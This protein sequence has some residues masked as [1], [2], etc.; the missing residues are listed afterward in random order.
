M[1]PV[2]DHALSVVVVMLLVHAIHAETPTRTLDTNFT[3]DRAQVL[4]TIMSKV[5]PI[6]ILVIRISIHLQDKK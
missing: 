3:T 4:N 6:A 2:E 1:V 5:G